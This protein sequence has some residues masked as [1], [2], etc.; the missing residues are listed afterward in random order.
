M[1]PSDNDIVVYTFIDNVLLI[2]F[3][4]I[5]RNRIETKMG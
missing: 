4:P 1:L 2:D 5:L 3:I